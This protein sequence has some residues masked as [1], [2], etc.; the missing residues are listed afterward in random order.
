MRLDEKKLLDLI[1]DA[2][3]QSGWQ[4]IVLGARKPFRIRVYREDSKGFDVCMYIWNCTH[5]G[6]AARAANEYRV[7]LTGTVPMVQPNAIT[8][9]LGWHGD[10]EVFVG[11]DLTMHAGQASKSPSIQVKEET[12]Q[13]AH[14]HAFAVHNRQNGENAVA[15]RPEFL[16]DYALSAK[17]LHATG[18]AAADMSLLNGLDTL[19]EEAVG[20]VSDAG[21]RL[22]LSQIVRKYR[23]TDF[24]KRVLGAYE[25]RCA[26]CGVQLELLDAA[27]IIPVAADTST[28]ETKNGIALCKL[29][30]AA[31]DRNLISFDESYKIEVSTSE[32]SRLAAVNLGGGIN[33]FKKNLRVAI[34]LPTDS[35]DYPP[36]VYIKEARRVRKWKS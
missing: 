31:Y 10:Y 22:V 7:Q 34:H 4:A 9:L 15:F 16:V 13:G 28:D 3:D 21:R 2:I 27:H 14:V 33:E 8:L 36:A 32:E 23:A 20:G 35:R 25:H 30:H 12:L 24:R 26:A 19:T 5:G 11:F 6:G 1:L 29:H 17:S 18:K